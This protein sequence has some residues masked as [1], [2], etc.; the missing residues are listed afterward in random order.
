MLANLS[1][2]LSHGCYESTWGLCIANVTSLLWEWCQVVCY[3][4]VDGD[5]HP[6]SRLLMLSLILGQLC[7]VPMQQRADRPALHVSCSVIKKHLIKCCIG[8]YIK[9][10]YPVL[11]SATVSLTGRGRGGYDQGGY[12]GGGGGY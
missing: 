3:M 7:T 9:L 6:L 1:L 11:S 4:D 10:F 5:S 12:G 8:C 2:Y